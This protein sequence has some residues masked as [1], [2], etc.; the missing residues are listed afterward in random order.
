MKLIL[1]D[2]F[3]VNPIDGFSANQSLAFAELFSQTLGEISA[4]SISRFWCIDSVNII[5]SKVSSLNTKHKLPC[6][7]NISSVFK[8]FGKSLLETTFIIAQTNRMVLPCELPVIE[9]IRL[10]Q[11]CFLCD[12]EQEKVIC[13]IKGSVLYDV[14][15]SKNPNSVNELYNMLKNEGIKTNIFPVKGE[16]APLN[17][18]ENFKKY[19]LK[20]LKSEIFDG[21]KEIKNGIFCVDKIPTGQFVAVPPVFFGKNVQIETGAVIGPSVI[22]GD[23]CLISEG[24]R[25]ENSIIAPDV[26]ISKDCFVNG[27]LIGEG[28]S[29][30]RNCAVLE[31]S[32]IGALS[33]I[34]E[35]AVIENDCYLPV[36]SVIGNDFDYYNT[37]LE[38]F[39]AKLLIDDQY[40]SPEDSAAIGKM[41]AVFTG[42]GETAVINDGTLSSFLL[43]NAFVAGA[44]FFGSKVVDCGEAAVSQCVTAGSIL[45]TDYSVFISASA[46]RGFAFFDSFGRPFSRR[47]VCEMC[48]RK[49]S[50]SARR[51]SAQYPL[52]NFLWRDVYANEIFDRLKLV[53]NIASFEVICQN[54]SIVFAYNAFE[55]FIDKT[56]DDKIIFTVSENSDKLSAHFCNNDFSHEKLLSIASLYELRRGSVI[57][58]PWNAPSFLS[59]CNEFDGK[60]KFGENE[61]TFNGAWAFDAFFLIIKILEAIDFTGK[62]LVELALDIPEFFIAERSLDI[63]VQP[64]V[65]SDNDDADMIYSNGVTRI[66][67]EHG[68]AKIKRDMYRNKLHIIT[69]AVNSEYSEELT[70][71][72]MKIINNA[73]L[74]NNCN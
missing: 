44:A 37:D 9:K 67:T 40:R 15:S 39:S 72:I 17:S 50:D 33:L 24:A 57:K 4:D 3:G 69:E 52:Y 55:Q 28:A 32:V 73:V 23:G 13:V 35:G 6:F 62:N 51:G 48:N 16:F 27:A 12:C 54:T 31:N 53:E 2:D 34:G 64:C 10:L 5:S 19:A 63:E 1:L 46:S 14:S 22:V 60:I 68:I 59:E 49:I 71:E 21:I 58:L 30:R 20:L 47:A 8:T 43:K 65:L 18:V 41:F 74:D 26:Y 42:G 38:G 25:I 29:L 11:P 66:K 61:G 36:S 56:G 45:K 70:G 7:K